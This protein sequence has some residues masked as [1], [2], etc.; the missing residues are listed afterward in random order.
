MTINTDEW[1]SDLVAVG[2]TKREAQVVVRLRT[3]MSIEEIAEELDL[4]ENTTRVHKETAKDKAS[5]DAVSYLLLYGPFD[6]LVRPEQFP[7][8]EEQ[9]ELGLKN[10]L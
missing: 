7:E 9:L 6:S 1:E 10:K 4:P 3:G 2:F 8:V 5:R